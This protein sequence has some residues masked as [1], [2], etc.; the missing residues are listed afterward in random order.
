[1]P[2]FK[3]PYSKYFPRLQSASYTYRKYLSV[4]ALKYNAISFKFSCY[5][6]T[7]YVYYRYYENVLPDLS[8]CIFN[9]N[10]VENYINEMDFPNTGMAE[11]CS[12]EVLRHWFG[13]SRSLVYLEQVPSTPL[14][15]T[16]KYNHIATRF[17]TKL[18]HNKIQHFYLSERRGDILRNAIVSHCNEKRNN[19]KIN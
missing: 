1:M 4:Q 16:T 11:A 6:I 9:F 14:N 17:Q 2:L 5:F 12:W 19:L 8:G 7:S 3:L 18:Y 10:Y 15:W 13:F